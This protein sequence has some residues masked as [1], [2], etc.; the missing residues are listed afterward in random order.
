MSDTNIEDYV[1]DEDKHR[2]V[3]KPLLFENSDKAKVGEILIDPETGALYVKRADGT[4]VSQ[5]VT[6]A[7]Q[8]K[9]LENAGI[10]QNA[11]AYINNAEVYTIYKHENKVRL[12]EMLKLSSNM[13]YYA[14]RG[15]NVITGEIEYITGNLNN[16][17]IENS[18]CDITH[19]L[20]NPS[21]E[22]N[23]TAS[24]GIIH[25]PANVLEGR[26][27][28]IEFYDKNR[29][30]ISSVPGQ[31]VEVQSLSFAL[32]PEYNCTGLKIATSQDTIVKNE[33]TGL[34]EEI[35]YLYQGQ[36][37]SALEIWVSAMFG[38][39]SIKLIN[40]DLASSRLVITIPENANSDV[41][42]NTFDI[43]ARYYTEEVNID[44]ASEEELVNY[45]SI[46]VTKRVKIIPDVFNHVKAIIPVPMVKKDPDNKA[47]DVIDLRLFAFYEDNK[48]EDVTQNVRT[49]VSAQFDSNEFVTNQQF[50][51]ELG[52]GSGSYQF[53]ENISLQMGSSPH[54]QLRKY[55]IEHAD[56]AANNKKPLTTTPV[57]QIDTHN[58]ELKNWMR[59]N[60]DAAVQETDTYTANTTQ[61]GTLSAFL[62]L[63]T[64]TKEVDGA[65]VKTVPT[66]F[67]VRSVIN[68]AFLH[69]ITPVPVANFTGFE[70]IDVAGTETLDNYK[71]A[72]DNI[73]FPVLVEYLTYDAD[74]DKYT[75]IA[76]VP[77]F[78]AI[79]D[80]IQ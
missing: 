14:I 69:T 34:D 33:T 43:T 71:I 39:G 18:L 56:W 7:N 62:A 54:Y 51:V 41:V 12:D 53:A 72:N 31:I 60:C 76:A 20:S 73:P 24:V 30:L 68:P 58:A 64:V 63:G 77:F 2:I 38:D 29:R 40:S 6:V 52:L 55:A 65:E 66:H 45:T 67:R 3:L 22:Y 36:N 9:D 49:T 42:G 79:T 44:G 17:A 48:L 32:T 4:I 59:L 28:T 26:V 5:A 78:T 74:T 70:Y 50:S 57:A 27:Y 8:L 21:V 46:S 10:I 1:Y 37:P 16:G 35:A 61:A 75:R 47:S 19:D 25:T 11:L 80:F 23:G 15:N 13:Y